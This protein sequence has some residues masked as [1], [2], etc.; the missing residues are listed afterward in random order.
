MTKVLYQITPAGERA[1]ADGLLHDY[2]YVFKDPLMLK[3][4]FGAHL[5]E[6]SSSR[7]SKSAARRFR[8]ETSARYLRRGVEP[9]GME[10][11]RVSGCD[12]TL[13]VW[14]PDYDGKGKA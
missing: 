12:A 2:P 11:V 10:R 1:L 13:V 7:R 8:S 3:V 5:P 6:A 14:S 4:F 9:E